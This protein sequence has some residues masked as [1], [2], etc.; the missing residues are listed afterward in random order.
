MDN[1]SAAQTKPLVSLLLLPR[2]NSFSFSTR[3]SGPLP[4][5]LPTT[6][7]CL[8]LIVTTCPS[9]RFLCKS[10]S[11]WQ[12]VA[13]GMTL[14]LFVSFT[15]RQNPFRHLTNL[16]CVKTTN[17]LI[18]VKNLNKFISRLPCSVNTHTHT[19]CTHAD[20]QSAF[21]GIHFAHVPLSHS[22]GLC[23]FP[24]HFVV[25]L[26]FSFFLPFFFFQDFLLRCVHSLYSLRYT[27][28]RF[29]V[30][31]LWT[32]IACMYFGVHDNALQMCIVCIFLPYFLSAACR[33]SPFPPF[34]ILIVVRPLT[35][36]VSL[37]P[38]CSQTL[39]IFF[40]FYFLIFMRYSIANKR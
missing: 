26:L 2:H 38:F 24:F 18:N 40:I 29:V 27:Y 37:F 39:H 23:L 11:S 36:L 19:Q 16:H 20:R 14:L 30:Y 32:P 10:H 28:V 31:A 35:R 21:A 12:I 7:L 22:P 15:E 25:C 9:K 33:W 1:I 3:P 34:C 13:I 17:K 8:C 6:P 4:P 5:F